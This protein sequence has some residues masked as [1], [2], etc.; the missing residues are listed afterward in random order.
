MKYFLI[1]FPC[2]CGKVYKVAIPANEVVWIFVCHCGR[3]IKSVFVE[4]KE[5]VNMSGYG[6]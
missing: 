1:D 3:T 6:K 4:N 5:L 2:D